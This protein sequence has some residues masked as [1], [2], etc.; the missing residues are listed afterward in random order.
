MLSRSLLQPKL[1]PL[2]V[3]TWSM[4]WMILSGREVHI[5]CLTWTLNNSINMA[6]S[7]ESALLWIDT[8]AAFVSM[9]LFF[10]L[11]CVATLL[12]S[13]ASHMVLV[14]EPQWNTQLSEYESAWSGSRAP[15]MPCSTSSTSQTEKTV[16]QCDFL[17]GWFRI[18]RLEVNEVNALP[19]TSFHG[20]APQWISL[21][22]GTAQTELR[23][24]V[25]V[26]IRIM[27]CVTQWGNSF[28]NSG[29]NTISSKDWALE[30]FVYLM[31][32]FMC[33]GHL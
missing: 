8:F 33:G 14:S 21:A 27:P 19:P 18:S 2:S 6:V 23:V 29:S 15:V 30:V 32:F 17:C 11:I 16:M 26:C 9:C 5:S 12:C 22:Y 20:V 10:F 24:C 3:K 13:P 1:S 25:S 28:F 31:A 7:P 4:R